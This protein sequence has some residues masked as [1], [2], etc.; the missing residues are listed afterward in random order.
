M[1]NAIK[2]KI[3]ISIICIWLVLSYKMIK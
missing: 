1:F 2:E 3:L